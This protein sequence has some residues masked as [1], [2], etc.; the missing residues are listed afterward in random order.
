MSSGYDVAQICIN[1]HII[2]DST[3]KIPEQN[4]KYCSKCGEVAINKCKACNANIHGA[5]YNEGDEWGGGYY[6]VRLKSP[7]AFC[8][9]C[10]KAYTWTELVLKAAKDL[11]DLLENI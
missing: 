7:P 2:N 10:G 4:Q 8:Y 3:K 5:F 1:G 11:A 9:N 6:E